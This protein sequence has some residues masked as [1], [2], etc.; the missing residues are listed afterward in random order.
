MIQKQG[1]NV[2]MA[3]GLKKYL[4]IMYQNACRQPKIVENSFFEISHKVN[5]LKK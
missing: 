2:K 5:L 3:Y 4:Y 1:Q